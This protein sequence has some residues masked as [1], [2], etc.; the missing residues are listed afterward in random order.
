MERF[1]QAKVNVRKEKLLINLNKF[2]ETVQQSKQQQVP[3]PETSG[4]A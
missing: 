1:I 4:F 3:P 2:R